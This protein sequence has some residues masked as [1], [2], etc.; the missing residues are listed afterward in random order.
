MFA[1]RGFIS[2]S[3]TMSKTLSGIGIVIAIAIVASI[4]LSYSEWQLN[5][6]WELVQ[7]GSL[8]IS[9][10]PDARVFIDQKRAGTLGASGSYTRQRVLPGTRNVLVSLEGA[11]P[12]TK[13]VLIES[14]KTTTVE[15]FLIPSAPNAKVFKESDAGY[16]LAVK[17]ITEATLPTPDNPL[18]S[19]DGNAEV[20]VRDNIIGSVW[21]GSDAA[22][23]RYYCHDSE[24]GPIT[25]LTAAEGAVRGVSF[26]GTRNDVLIV[27]IKNGI[28][29][30]DVEPAGNQAQNDDPSKNQT[31]NFQPLYLGVE[32]LF[33]VKD[34]STVY[35][36][37][38]AFFIEL[39]L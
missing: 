32:P 37:D 28:W 35:I 20:Y 21:R 38:G 39:T 10:L 19:E 24:C 2:Y 27:A 12:W 16:A 34:P 25:V 22:M 13:N 17:A 23:P 30:L 33:A 9:G 26:F 36:Q 31:Q 8:T 5:E 18:A 29:A 6:R 1:G 7:T 15:P 14:G 3:T 11:W 4:A